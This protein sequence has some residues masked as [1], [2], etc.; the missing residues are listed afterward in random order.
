MNAIELSDKLVMEW[1][2]DSLDSETALNAAAMLR[3]QHN[4]L[5]LMHEAIVKLRGALVNMIEHCDLHQDV[6]C[7]EQALQDTEDLK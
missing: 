3:R 2:I 6:F 7:A 4:E 1:S 5:T